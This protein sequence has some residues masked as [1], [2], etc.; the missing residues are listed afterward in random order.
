MAT[1]KATRDQLELALK[2][3]QKELAVSHLRAFESAKES[4]RTENW[5]T[6][7][8]GPNADIRTA[9]SLLTRRH[10]DLVDSNPWANRAIRVI[11]N[12]WVGVGC[13]PRRISVRLQRR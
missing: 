6:R 11:Q 9:W 1:K 13:N 7:N 4:R 10:Q 8:G 12:N 2:S 5:Y 3:A